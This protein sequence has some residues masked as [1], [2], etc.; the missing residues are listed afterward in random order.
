MLFRSAMIDIVIS[1]KDEVYAKITCE[2]HIARELSEFFTFYVP[3]YQFTPAYKN[4]LW[5]GKIRMYDM[6]SN[7]MYHGL[8][9]YIE[10]FCEER[11]Y[12]LAID[13]PVNISEN[14]SGA[15]AK[16]S[17]PCFA[18]FIKLRGSDGI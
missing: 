1:K 18:I 8:V 4:R 12:K 7:K 17:S 5:D 15:E 13:T 6:R 14:F 16:E 9:A 2:R 10:K 11:N 3:G